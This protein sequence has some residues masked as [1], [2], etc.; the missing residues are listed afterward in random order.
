MDLRLGNVDLAAREITVQ[1]GKGDKMRVVFIGNKVVAA[2]REYI[3][4]PQ[5][6]TA[7]TCFLAAKAER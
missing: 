1:H 6:P 5:E 3:Q 2:I 7:P 4:E